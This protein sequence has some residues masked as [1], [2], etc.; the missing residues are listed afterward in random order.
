[1]NIEKALE[2]A[3][4]CGL[5]T[6]DE[7]IANVELHWSNVFEYSKMQEEMHELYASIKPEHEG[8]LIVDV[9]SLERRNE[10]DQELND[11]F[12]EQNKK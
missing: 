4:I 12:D 7:A 6:V 11:Y 8:K 3:Y 5:E 1:M 10:L 2:M 9:L